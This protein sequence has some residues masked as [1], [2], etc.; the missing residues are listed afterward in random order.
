MLKPVL[1]MCAGAVLCAILVFAP[2]LYRTAGMPY[3]ISVPERTL[4]RIALCSSQPAADTFYRA[5]TVYMKEHPAVHFRVTR[6]DAETLFASTQY[7][8]DLYV[9]PDTLAHDSSLFFS[10]PDSGVS[11]APV[12]FSESETLL[13]AVSSDTRHPTQAHD[14]FSS[15][16]SKLPDASAR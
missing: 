13:C 6:N 14:L 3:P 8:F 10:M 7:P 4:L 2:E 16:A 11:C 9:F 15:L 1:R 12:V 5:L